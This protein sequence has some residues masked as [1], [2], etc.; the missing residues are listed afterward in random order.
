MPRKKLYL[1]KIEPAENRPL[2]HIFRWLCYLLF[3]FG[4][5]LF[6]TSG[7]FKKPVLLLPAALCIAAVSE[8]LI[9][10]SVGIFCGLLMD[11]TQ[12]TFLGCHAI[13]LMLFSIAVSLLFDRLLMLRFFNML[14]LTA[15]CAWIFHSLDFLFSYVIWRYEG[16]SYLYVHHTLLC[17]AL[18]TGSLLLIY[19]LFALIHKFFLPRR[20]RKIERRVKDYDEDD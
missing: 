13:E 12:N 20:L 1:P 11:M 8:P 18:T 3:F 17:A 4:A 10:A 7:D 6:A 16:L 15:L 2:K 19:P 14:W 5:F 9:A